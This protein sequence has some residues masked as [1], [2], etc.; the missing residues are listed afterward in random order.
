MSKTTSPYWNPLA[1]EQAHRWRWME[2]LENQVQEL[3]LSE[4]PA[5]GELT[6]LT[7]FL[8]GADTAAFGGKAHAFPEE[9]FIVSGRLFDA[10]LG[11][12]LESGHY[13]SRPPGRCM[14]RSAPMGRAA[15]CL[16][17]P[18]PSVVW[19]IQPRPN[20]NDSI[21]ENAVSWRT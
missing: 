6:R 16:T 13:A 4:D 20:L 1:P 5:S 7:R 3:V 14:A 21:Q 15:W 10:A 18:F 9:I 17:S 2:G 19:V 11:L 8:P 12:W